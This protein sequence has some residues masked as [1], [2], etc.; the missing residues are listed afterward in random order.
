MADAAGFALNEMSAAA[1]GG[2]FA[3]AGATAQDIGTIYYNPAGLSRMTG[4]QFMAAGSLVRPSVRF[5]NEGSLSAAGTRMLGG[6]GGDAGDLSLVP[7]VFYAGDLASGWRFGIGLQSPF[8]LKTDYDAGWAGRYQALRSELKTININP[9]LSYALS[10]RLSIGMGISAQYAKV[11]LS[12]A[13][14]FGSACVGALGAANCVRAGF[15]P[16]ARDGKVTLDGT[17]WAFGFNLGLLYAPTQATRFGL[18]YRSRIR[19]DIS[20]GGAR[21]DKPAGLPAPLAAAASFS[22]TGAS[23]GLDLPETINLSAYT[24]LDSRW[25]VMGDINW[26]RW[27]RFEELR[28]RFDNGAPDSVVREQW[29]NVFRVGLGASYRYSEPFTLRGGLSYE[30]SPVK[31]A[32][33]TPSVPDA[34]RILL[35]FG[36]QY[37]PTPHS[38]WDIGYAHV[39]IKDAPIDKAEPP[40]GGRLTGGYENDVNVLSIQYTHTF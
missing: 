14:D 2:A 16:Q 11:E 29:R 4:R 9:T 26:T 30:Q 17:D 24:E 25:A 13:I 22:D 38:A 12:R 37:R 15:L 33:R 20:G 23:A 31:D 19:H 35:A 7:A 32:F 39:F 40:L 18:A 10:D 27:S 3:G 21:Y 34:R 8:G 5:G 28:I 1:I 36:A 6:N